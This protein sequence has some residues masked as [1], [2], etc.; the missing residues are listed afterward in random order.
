MKDA[1]K[2]KYGLIRYYASELFQ[3]SQGMNGKSTL[4][5]PLFFEFPNDPKAYL[6]QMYNVM[7]GDALKLSINPRNLQEKQHNY[8]FP[9]GVWCAV[10]GT[11]RDDAGK[12]KSLTGDCTTDSSTGQSI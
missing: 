12:L 1:I 4:F 2:L 8:Y 7:L 6:D 3:I 9:A 11:K 5:K 10:A